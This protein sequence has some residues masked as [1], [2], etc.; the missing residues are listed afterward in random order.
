MGFTTFAFT[1]PAKPF[2]TL[3][4]LLF[5]VMVMIFMQQRGLP[6]RAEYNACFLSVLLEWFVPCLVFPEWNRKPAI[7]MQNL[8]KMHS[9]CFREW[10]PRTEKQFCTNRSKIQKGT[11][12]FT[13][14]RNEFCKWQDSNLQEGQMKIQCVWRLA[15]LQRRLVMSRL[16]CS[17]RVILEFLITLL[18]PALRPSKLTLQK[19]KKHKT[20]SGGT[21]G[22]TQVL[23]IP[24]GFL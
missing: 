19:Y 24:H 8:G 23:E 13:A 17:K 12:I 2:T 6:H 16:R 1:C 11:S 3:P 10:L 20:V 18:P 15:A 21:N 5:S 22:N 7:V 4:W 9:N 14:I